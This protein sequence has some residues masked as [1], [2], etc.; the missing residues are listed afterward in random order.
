MLGIKPFSV[1]RI[2]K[3]QG[4]IIQVGLGVYTWEELYKWSF[5]FWLANTDTLK[6]KIKA[7]V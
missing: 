6:K 5:H 3:S 4:K 2:P 1:Q 7:Q